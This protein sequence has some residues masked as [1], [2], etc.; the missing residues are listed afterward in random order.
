ME[1]SNQA[2]YAK[3]S[4]EAPIRKSAMENEFFESEPNGQRIKW[5]VE[6]VDVS[7]TIDVVP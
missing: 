1:T 2:V 7:G 3:A 4:G 5:F 6:Y